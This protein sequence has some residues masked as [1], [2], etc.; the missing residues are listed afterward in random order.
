MWYFLCGLGLFVTIIWP[1]IKLITSIFSSKSNK[2]I[3]PTKETVM[4]IDFATLMTK[5][6]Q[7]NLQINSPLIFY[8][9][10][11]FLYFL[12]DIRAISKNIPETTRHAALNNLILTLEYNHKL[13][14]LTNKDDFKNIFSKRYA[15]YLSI[16]SDDNY[17]FSDKFFNTVYEYQTAQI[18]S[19]KNKNKFTTFNPVLNC[20]ENTSE[21]LKVKSIV[22]D[23]F[24]LFDSFMAQQ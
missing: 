20:L 19:I 7:N 11:Y 18:I 4:L 5:H 22:S 6:I 16:L 10:L 24:H 23:N 1:I 21:E 9:Q 12:K 17:D 3:I 2:N 13:D 14:Y 8:E 15:T